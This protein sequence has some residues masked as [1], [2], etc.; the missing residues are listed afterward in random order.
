M[1]VQSERQSLAEQFNSPAGPH[2]CSSFKTDGVGVSCWQ[3]SLH[4]TCAQSWQMGLCAAD[5]E[6]D[7]HGSCH[8][9]PSHYIP[10]LHSLMLTHSVPTVTLVYSCLIGMTPHCVP[11]GFPYLY[12][13]KL[14]K[15]PCTWPKSKRKWC[16]ENSCCVEMQNPDS[17]TNMLQDPLPIHICKAFSI[18][19]TLNN[20]RGDQRLG[21]EPHL[22]DVTGEGMPLHISPK[23]SS[24]AAIHGTQLTNEPTE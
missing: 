19:A 4:S 6:F 2:F 15:I 23:K 17:T 7:R 11:L 1:L 5:F 22:K 13:N 3:A 18:N 8:M 12:T 24:C 20:S 10:A 21:T 14:L 16:I 9:G